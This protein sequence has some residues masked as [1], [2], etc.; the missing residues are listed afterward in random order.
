MT[1]MIFCPCRDCSNVKWWADISKI[2]DHLYC[3]VFRLDYEICY[4]LGEKLNINDE[5]AEANTFKCQGDEGIAEDRMNDMMDAFGDHLTQQ[6]RMFENVSNAV[7]TPL[8]DGCSKYSE[9]SA[10]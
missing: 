2:V 8:Y 6:T 9:L 5:G 1:P 4:W 10:T 7:E 3:R